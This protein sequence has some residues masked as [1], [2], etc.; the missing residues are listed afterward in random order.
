MKYTIFSDG[1][2]RG[3]P[4]PAGAGAVIYDEDKKIIAEISEYLG[5]MTNNQAEYTALILALEKAKELNAKELDCYL[6]S[7]LVVKQLK[8]EYRVKDKKLEPL[9][10]KVW[11]LTFSFEKV[12]FSHVMREKN[13][14]AD[15]LVNQAIDK[16]V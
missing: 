9:F 12:N 6:D 1:G 14:E 4:G 16:A 15:R 5:K 3:N 10:V 13:K 11:N 8:R 7:D 2:A